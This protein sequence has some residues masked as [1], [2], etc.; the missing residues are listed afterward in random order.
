MRKAP[1]KL[2]IWV[3]TLTVAL[4]LAGHSM[5]AGTPVRAS[6]P[7][8]AFL[9]PDN[10]TPRWTGQDAPDFKKALQRDDPSAQVIVDVANEDP[11]TQLA[12]A[13]AALTRGAKVLVVVAVDENQAASIVRAAHRAHAAVI[14]YTRL[15]SNSPVDYMI[16]DNPHQIGVVLGRWVKNHTQR[17]A[18]VAVING[19]AADSFA[20]Q[21]HA[22]YFSILGPLFR[23]GARR[24]V[25]NV[26][27]P[28]WDPAKAHAEMN[29]ILTQSHGH[30]QAVLS[31]NDGMAAGIIAALSTRGLA[32]KVPVTGIDATLASDQLILKGEQSMSVWR[33][34]ATEANYTARVVNDLLH[35]RKPPK[36]FFN[37]SVYNGAVRIPL[38][39]VPSIVIDRSNMR[40]LIKEHVYTRRDLCSG[41]GVPHIGV[42]K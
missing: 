26:W 30:L 33:S 40:I 2:L 28:A 42:C 7:L 32:G 18:T 31:G 10:T 35:N 14:A 37:G 38:K 24:V 6:G 1:R 25:G 13:Q 9:L 16:G 15:I 34:I 20:H 11:S 39:A 17:G 4:G 23:S 29:A 5:G 19:S 36:S 22:G 12:Q 8:V 27:T 3:V 41:S 21:E